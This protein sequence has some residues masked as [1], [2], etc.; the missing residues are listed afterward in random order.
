MERNGGKKL[1]RIKS[2]REASWI[3]TATELVTFKG[4]F[5]N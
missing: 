3:Q 2:I 5:Q 1:L 4:L